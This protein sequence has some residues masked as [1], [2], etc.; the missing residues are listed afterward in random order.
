MIQTIGLLAGAVIIGYTL[1]QAYL[2][3]RED[4]VNRRTMDKRRA[5]EPGGITILCHLCE[6][7]PEHAMSRKKCA[8]CA[9]LAC[10]K[11]WDAQHLRCKNCA[12][13]LINGR[14]P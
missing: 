2:I 14:N 3:R 1:R 12:A 13:T 7:V 10:P 11:C 4:A 9:R 6:A 5:L 8:Y